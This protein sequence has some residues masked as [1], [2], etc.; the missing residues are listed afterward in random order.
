MVRILFL[1]MLIAAPTV[2]AQLPAPAPLPSI[3]ARNWLLLD[4]Q[5]GQRLASEDA[6]ERIEPA[7]LTKLMSAYVVF[8]ALRQKQLSLEQPVPVSAKAWKMPGSR[9]FLEPGTSVTVDELLRGLIVVSGND[10]AVALAEAVGGT[11]DAFVERMNAQARR[12]GLANTHFA[13]ATG[14]PHAQHYT[15]VSDLAR[16]SR[17]LVGDFPAFVPLY[18]LRAFTHNGITQPNRNWLLGRDPRVD[19][20]KTGHTESAGYC[21]I[22]T[23][24]SDGRHLLVIVTGTASESARAIEAQKLL[25]YGLQHYDTVRL[26]AKGA[27]VAQLPVRRGAE[28]SV[29][30]GFDQD[31]YVSVPRGQADRLEATLS[32]RQPLLAPVDTRQPVGVL[33]L[34]FDGKP[35]G[36]F[37]VVALESVRV[38]SLLGRA[39]DSLLLWFE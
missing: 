23:A 2:S 26:Y 29:R 38:A 24:R 3:A 11:E 21:L 22:A 34:A 17:A 10:A 32:S 20:L 16:L 4:L 30:A 13:N 28:K 36:E 1:I 25:N 27:V 37:A 6:D 35:L 7:S 9:M 31:L 12:L 14:L 19:G 5:S 8:E 18:S 15:T 39:W 33:R